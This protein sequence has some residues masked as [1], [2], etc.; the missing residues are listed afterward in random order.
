MNYVKFNVQN[1]REAILTH[2]NGKVTT[3]TDQVISKGDAL[4]HMMYSKTLDTGLSTFVVKEIIEEREG[5]GSYP[6]SNPP[7]FRS[8]E[9]ERMLIPYKELEEKGFVRVSQQQEN[10]KTVTKAQLL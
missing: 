8:M 1:S 9:V 6:K 10:G 4:I 7:T 2:K 5:K 3:V